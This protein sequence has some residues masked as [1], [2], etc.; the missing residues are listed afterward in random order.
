MDWQHQLVSDYMVI[1]QC[2]QSL[3][4]DTVNFQGKNQ[5]SDTEIL[6]VYFWGMRNGH[7]TVKS[8]HIF[9]DCYLKTWFPNLP[10]YQQFVK[11]LNQLADVLELVFA[12]VSLGLDANV[13]SA[14]FDSMP[15]VL[16][17]ARR[18]NRAKVAQD[19]CSKGYCASKKMW[20]YGVKLHLVINADKNRAPYTI[21]LGDFTAASTHDIEFLKKNFRLINAERGYGDKAYLSE[22]MSE[23][24]RGVGIELLCPPKKPRQAELSYAQHFLGCIVSGTRQAI[25]TAFNWLNAH[26]GLGKASHI[27]S[28]NGLRRHIFGALLAVS[29]DCA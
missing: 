11:R 5:F 28:S 25:E 14:A 16:A 12:V 17:G 29:L 27:R 21:V 3:P 6:A 7:R 15:V 18:S 24:M 23:K 20:Y 9:A 2:L 10:G 8:I 13:V 1:D 22:E 19:L 26:T 4:E